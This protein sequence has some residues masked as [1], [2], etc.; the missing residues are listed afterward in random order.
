MKAA[1]HAIPPRILVV[2]NDPLIRLGTVFMLRE[3]GLTAESAESTLHAHALIAGGFV[4]DLLITDYA[5]PGGNGAA[6]AH[7]LAELNPD[8]LVLIVTGH[9]SIEEPLRDAWRILTKPFTSAELYDAIVDMNAIA[10]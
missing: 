8:L 6:L 2:D 3:N 4:P 5:M 10:L 7:E 9:P 1:D